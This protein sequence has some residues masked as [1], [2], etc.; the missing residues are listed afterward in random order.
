[1][2]KTNCPVSQGKI[3]YAT[4]PDGTADVWIRKN[5]TQLP[6]SEE[7]PQGVEADEIYFKVTVS[8]V[9]KEE[10]SADIDFWF[11][12]LKEKEEG[13]NADYLSIETYRA[14]KKKEISQI[15]QSTV[16]A[17]V[18]I[19]ISSGTEHFSLKDEDQLN[20]FGKQAQL[21]AGSEKLE[22]HEDGKYKIEQRKADEEITH[23]TGRVLFWLH[24]AIV[25][26]E[27][28]VRDCAIRTILSRAGVNGDGLR[29]LDKATYA[30]VVN[31]CLRVAKGDA[32]IKIAD[33]KVSAVHGGDKHDYCILD[34]KAIAF[35]HFF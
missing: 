9:T 31:Y 30:K 11:D 21:A 2:H 6:E 12:Q 18:D 7:G 13:L 26:G 3:T 16:F 25:K 33:G 34:M 17:G 23:A 22:Y 20:L 10:I 28:P 8:T 27:H 4:L 32:L 35:L 14:N 1:M 15:C 29:K 19:S 5:E 24:H